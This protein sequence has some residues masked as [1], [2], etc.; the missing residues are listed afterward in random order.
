MLKVR[1]ETGMAHSK[2][3]N[4]SRSYKLS[5]TGCRDVEEI[6]FSDR[7]LLRNCALTVYDAKV[8]V[9]STVKIDP[10]L[11]V[12][13]EIRQGLRLVLRL[14]KQFCAFSLHVLNLV[15]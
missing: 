11:L 8:D 4:L 10:L 3:V 1:R 7:I 14:F 13:V 12:L 2:R 9:A 6:D 15:A 5:V